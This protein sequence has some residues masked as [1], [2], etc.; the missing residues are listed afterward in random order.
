MGT[1]CLLA[2][3]G[4][5]LA[6]PGA[7]ADERTERLCAGIEVRGSASLGLSD[8]ERRLVCGDPEQDAVGDAWSRIPLNQAQYHL[9]VFLQERGYFQPRFEREEGRLIVNMGERTRVTR[10]EKNI[11]QPDLDLEKRRG[12][13]GEVLTPK[14][15]DTAEGW[16]SQKLQASGFPCPDVTS[17]AYA[18]TGAV[19]LKVNPGPKLPLVRIVEEELPGIAPGVLRRYDAFI[20]G[21]TYNSEWLKVTA[22]RILADGVLQS[23]S[24]IPACGARGSAE[25]VTVRQEA[26]PGLP[27]LLGFGFGINTEGLILGK[28]SWRNARLGRHAS[29]LDFTAIGSSKEQEFSSSF[30]WYPAPSRRYVRPSARLRHE[31]EEHY[32]IFSFK[33]QTAL[34]TS[35]DTQDLGYVF[36]LG[37]AF[38]YFRTLG[39]IGPKEADFVSLE[40][41]ARLTSHSYEYYAGS[42]RTGFRV[43][44]S[45]NSSLDSVLADA[46]AHRLGFAAE[47]LWNYREYESPLVV[48]GTRMGLAST[49]GVRRDR[50]GAVPAP[51][52]YW[53]GGS[54]DLRGFGRQEVP[55]DDSGGLSTAFAGFEVRT[56]ALLPQN[57]Q[58]LLFID[59]GVVG[60]QGAT[61]Q[62]PV[63]WSPGFG[64]RWDS[65]IGAVRSTLAHGYLSGNPDPSL[66]HW[67][68]Y[69]SLGEEF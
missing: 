26:I 52:R 16:A 15:L 53:L 33:G 30:T 4:D 25:G 58:P 18:E 42:P 27:R 59:A 63:Y 51:F 46:T 1:L 12:L 28:A 21:E 23:V 54:K 6:A 66:S 62:A 47:A 50:A 69:L 35:L 17:E 9:G 8:A 40:A 24:F 68:F 45:G 22:Q 34:G 36:R 38:E 2:H 14:L 43:R 57:F 61:L 32:Q 41:E 65:P 11:F 48:F 64:V 5:A 39:G 3:F 13:V 31:N 10:L 19:L 55:N 37:P 60:D 44:F 29:L 67:Q 49:L 20:L 56:F 7:S